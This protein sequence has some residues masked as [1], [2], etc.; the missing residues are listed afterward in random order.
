MRKLLVSAALLSAAAMAAPASAQYY[1]PPSRAP[2]V[3]VQRDVADI[4]RGIERAAWRGLLSRR[5]ASRLFQRARGIEGLAYRYQ[6]N[7][8]SWR[9][10][11]ELRER[12]Y[13]LRQQL[14]AEKREGERERR[15]DRRW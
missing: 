13:H 6:R 9:E 1:G 14:H 5:E 7:G 8:L 10:H 15:Y 12:I 4:Q 2:I 3:Q 11:R